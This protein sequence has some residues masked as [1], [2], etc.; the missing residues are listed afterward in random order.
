MGCCGNV[1]IRKKIKIRILHCR[2]NLLY[3]FKWNKKFQIQ[4]NVVF[5]SEFLCCPFVRSTTFLAVILSNVLVLL[6]LLLINPQF[7]FEG[8]MAW[9][10]LKIHRLKTYFMV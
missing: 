1:A 3:Y 8:I 2:I 5:Y 6:F 9:R 7:Y 10:H 4:Q